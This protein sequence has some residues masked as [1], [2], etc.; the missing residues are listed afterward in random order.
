MRR[1][2]LSSPRLFWSL[3][4]AFFGVLET[5][6]KCRGL[7]GPLLVPIVFETRSAGIK[8]KKPRRGL[9]SHGRELNPQPITYEAIALPIE[10]PWRRP[11]Y[12]GDGRD[13]TRRG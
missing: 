12:S 13:Y 5:V 6:V 7:P 3:E 2:R 4:I 9:V 1:S 10:L 8:R 11:V